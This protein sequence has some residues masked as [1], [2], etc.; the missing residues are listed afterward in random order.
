[1]DKL[2]VNKVA[3]NVYGQRHSLADCADFS[4]NIG[5]LISSTLIVVVVSLLLNPFALTDWSSW[6]N[7]GGETMHAL[8]RQFS[9]CPGQLKKS[10]RQNLPFTIWGSVRATRIGLDARPPKLVSLRAGDRK[11]C[12]CILTTNPEGVRHEDIFTSSVCSVYVILVGCQRERQGSAV[13][14]T[15]LQL[16]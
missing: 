5:P 10:I 4:N 1:M 14:C 13:R 7:F 2:A 6:V 3:P 11:L 15:A 9:S 8:V 12:R 16:Q